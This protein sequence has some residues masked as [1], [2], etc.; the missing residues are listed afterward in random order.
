MG[1]AVGEVR[2]CAKSMQ[3]EDMQPPPGYG[4]SLRKKHQTADGEGAFGDGRV[5]LKRTRT[6]GHRQ[7][8]GDCV[9]GGRGWVEVEEGTR[10][11]SSNGKNIIKNKLF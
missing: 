4:R 8:C 2:V 6:H 3:T 10:E 9:V 11:V 5:E 7:Q 1:Q